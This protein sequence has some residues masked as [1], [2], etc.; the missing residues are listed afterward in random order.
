MDDVS[1][2]STSRCYQMYVAMITNVLEF[3]TRHELVQ[4]FLRVTFMNC[5]C[6]YFSQLVLSRKSSARVDPMAAMCSQILDRI[7]GKASVRFVAKVN[8]SQAQIEARSKS[9]GYGN[10]L[11]TL[12]SETILH[13][14][15]DTILLAIVELGRFFVHTNLQ[16]QTEDSQMMKFNLLST[17]WRVS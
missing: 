1:E 17:S 13:V 14:V 8:R 3:L 6:G 5:E 2:V 11:R 12:H 4:S 15:T 16:K 9:S 10:H 7:H